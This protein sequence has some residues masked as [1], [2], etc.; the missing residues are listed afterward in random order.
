MDRIS[1][2]MSRFGERKFLIKPFPQEMKHTYE[3]PVVVAIISC[4]KAGSG[5]FGLFLSGMPHRPEVA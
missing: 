5:R 3:P 1:G 2:F 4:F